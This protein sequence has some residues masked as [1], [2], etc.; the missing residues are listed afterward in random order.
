MGGDVEM[1]DSAR[2]YFH[3]HEDIQDAKAGRHG[4]KEITGS[5][6]RCAQAKAL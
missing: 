2:A 4:G 3:Y 1:G 5:K 6:I